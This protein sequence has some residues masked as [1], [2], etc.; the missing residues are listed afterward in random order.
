MADNETWCPLPWIHLYSD[1]SGIGPCCRSKRLKLHDFDSYLKSTELATLK[2]DMV[3][4]RKNEICKF[5]HDYGDG[6]ESSVRAQ[7]IEYNK[8][9]IT[10]DALVNKIM[11]TEA[12]FSSVCNFKCRICSER[13]STAIAK[14]AGSPTIYRTLNGDLLDSLKAI[15]H[16]LIWVQFSGGEPF[17]IPEHYEFLQY[18]KDI[19]RANIMKLTYTT[20]GS[21]THY[22]RQP[23]GELLEGFQTVYIAFSIDAYGKQAEYWRHGTVWNELVSN[24]EYFIGLPHVITDFSTTVG[25][26]NLF[27]AIKAAQFLYDRFGRH[28]MFNRV[29]SPNDRLSVEALPL[30]LKREAERQL[31]GLIRG[32]DHLKDASVRNII[33]L[34]YNSDKSEQ[35]RDA[36]QEQKRLDMLRGENFFDVFPEYERMRG[37]YE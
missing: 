22:K 32:E 35:L 37:L 27:S 10:Q 16:D 11:I 34:L 25:W 18:L 3:A 21:V 30:D 7:M 33:G 20:N 19:G 36:L 28:T 23:I 24:V 15:A 8:H 9:L 17:L 12:R 29:F 1:V 14:E 31:T 4:G 26:P 6:M 2:E 13:Y 5:C